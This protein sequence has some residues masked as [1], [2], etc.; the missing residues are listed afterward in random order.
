[1][2]YLEKHKIIHCDLCASNILLNENNDAKI[3][4]FGLSR[5][6]ND[7]KNGI[8]TNNKVR[9]RWTAPEVL[10]NKYYTIKADVWSFGV[11]LWVLG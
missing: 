5:N 10:E 3:S 6:L 8:I 9:I 7:L 4:D 2:A 1:M 11:L